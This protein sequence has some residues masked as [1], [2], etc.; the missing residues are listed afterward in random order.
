MR[1]YFIVPFLIGLVPVQAQTDPFAG[2]ERSRLHVRLELAGS[3]RV[4]LPNGVEWSALS[5]VRTLELTYALV[6]VANDGIP[7]VGGVPAGTVPPAMRDLEAKLAECGDSQACLAAVMMEFA[8]SGQGGQNPF[9]AMTG[10]QPGRYR[11]FSADR[12]AGACVDGTVM[13]DDILSGVTIPPPNPAV[14]YRFTRVGALTLPVEVF[15]TID[16]ICAAE[17]S[18]DT[19]TG[20]MSLRLPV[21]RIDVPVTMGPSAFTDEQAVRFVEGDGT[22]ELLD[23]PTGGSWSGSADLDALGSASHNSGQVVVGLSG[24]ISWQLSVG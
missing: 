1:F 13:V 15:A 3:G 16:A 14:A 11:N 17:V 23:R 20:T 2:N 5:A 7:I 12:A 21:G 24:R 8:G 9:A 18:L 6:D 10:M 4:D 22:L 19:Q